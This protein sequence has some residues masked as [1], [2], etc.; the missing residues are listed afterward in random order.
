[1][2]IPVAANNNSQLYELNKLGNN[3][4]VFTAKNA[5]TFWEKPV[6]KAGEYTTTS[7]TLTVR[8]STSVEQNIKLRT[9]EFPYNNEE[10]LRYLNHVYITIQKDSAV[11]Y[12]GPYSRIND[13]R[14]FSI[15]AVLAANTEITYSIEMRCDYAYT[16][17]G[18]ATDDLIEWEFYTVQEAA[19]EPSSSPFSDPAL[20]EVLVACGIAVLLLGGVFLYDRFL[21]KHR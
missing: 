4:L 8:N 6:L 13:D 16:G 5:P 20:L 9:V 14:D 11:L 21:K 3:T 18:L 15:N 17:E 12:D 2:G 7:G 19:E 10:A 1:M